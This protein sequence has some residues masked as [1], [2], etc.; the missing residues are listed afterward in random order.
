MSV[1]NSKTSGKKAKRGSGTRQQVNVPSLKELLARAKPC[2]RPQLL[3]W[4]EPVG[5][6]I[7]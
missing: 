5:K 3:N 4:G 7:W 1:R 6:E 2:K